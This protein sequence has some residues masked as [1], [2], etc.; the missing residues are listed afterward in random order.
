MCAG[1]LDVTDFKTCQIFTYAFISRQYV[2]NVHLVRNLIVRM[3]DFSLEATTIPT[4]CHQHIIL[5]GGEDIR[6]RPCKLA[7]SELNPNFTQ[8]CHANAGEMRSVT[9]QSSISNIRAFIRR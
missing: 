5:V 1:D 2:H 8:M 4:P 7:A 6:N 3:Q 9:C